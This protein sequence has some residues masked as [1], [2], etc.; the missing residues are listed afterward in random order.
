MSGTSSSGLSSTSSPIQ[1]GGRRR[2]NRK[3]KGGDI[4]EGNTNSDSWDIEKGNK[5]ATDIPSSSHETHS[6]SLDDYDLA[7]QGMAGPDNKVGGTRRNRRR[8]SYKSA[9]RSRKTHR[10]KHKKTRRGGKSHRR[11]H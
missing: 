11:R 6:A 4:E 8:K 1:L 3:Y 2:R 5:T 9:K 10:R 7:E